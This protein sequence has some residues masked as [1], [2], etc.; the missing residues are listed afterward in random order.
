MSV[1]IRLSRVGRKKIPH[2]RIVVMDSRNRRDGVF[3]DKIGVYDPRHE[4]VRVE[5]I[6][7]K[8]LEWLSRG[9]SPSE[10]VRSLLSRQ[11]IMLRFDL[12]KRDTPADRVEEAVSKWKAEAAGR[13]AQ[14]AQRKAQRRKA[15]E[16]A[17]ETPAAAPGE[18]AAAS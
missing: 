11:G 7:R 2:Y 18:T 17:T 1:R 10:T 15:K 3:L 13:E 12:L 16:K 14:R 4:P 5:I 6:E 9:A 8:A